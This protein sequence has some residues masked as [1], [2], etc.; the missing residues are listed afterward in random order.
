MKRQSAI[1]YAV[2]AGFLAAMILLGAGCDLFRS[3]TV[4]P[5][6]ENG[7][8][9]TY[10]PPLQP[11]SVF[12]NFR[13]ALTEQNQ[14][15]YMNCFFAAGD[16][17]GTYQFIPDPNVTGWQITTP[18]G[19]AEENQTIQY[20][21]SLMM[22]SSPPFLSLTEQSRTAYGVDSV[23]ISQTYHLLAPTS[24]PL[25]PSEVRGEADYVLAR[26][27]TGFWAIL[28]WTDLHGLEGQPSWTALKAGLY[29]P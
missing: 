14:Q 16:P 25:L 18:W 7:N 17:G 6:L 26:T 19:Y 10:P 11:D 2:Q 21:F 15:E 24:D 22:P 4:E 20:L 5:P 1:W 3:R 8:G 29:S 9:V 27:E 12:V 23:K 13:N 28:R